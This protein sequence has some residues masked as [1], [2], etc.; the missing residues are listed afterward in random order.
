MNLIKEGQSCSVSFPWGIKGD[1][2]RLDYKK[3]FFE[4]LPRALGVLIS[5]LEFAP[6]PR[7]IYV[8][9]HAAVLRPAVSMNSAFTRFPNPY[10]ASHNVVHNVVQL[11]L[12]YSYSS[13]LTYVILRYNLQLQLRYSYGI[14]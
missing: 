14:S 7:K 1:F 2:C 9:V 8:D 10:V 6:H 11:Q 13:N 4:G 3:D 5:F 12:P